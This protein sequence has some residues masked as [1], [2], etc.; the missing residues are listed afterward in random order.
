MNDEKEHIDRLKLA[1]GQ[2]MKRVPDAV[3]NGSYQMAVQYKADYRKADK[4]LKKANPKINELGW[5]IGA[6]TKSSDA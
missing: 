2:A 3:A 6:M 4:I 5:A 1:L